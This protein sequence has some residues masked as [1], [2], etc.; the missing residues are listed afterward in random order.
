MY[1][2]ICVASC[3][4]VCVDLKVLSLLYRSRVFVTRHLTPLIFVQ[5]YGWKPENYTNQDIPYEI[6]DRYTPDHLTITCQG[7]VSRHLLVDMLRHIYLC[8]YYFISFHHTYFYKF[9]QFTQNL[10]NWFLRSY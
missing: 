7:E 6:K 9:S 5:I 4:F 2:R 10:I 8:N 3:V 1:V